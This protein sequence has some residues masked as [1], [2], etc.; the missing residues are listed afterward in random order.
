MQQPR[1]AP[2]SNSTPDMA[3]SVCGRILDY[4]TELD[5]SGGHWTHT[6][7]DA[8]VEDHRAVPVEVGSGNVVALYRCDFCNQD[9]ATWTVPATDF[10]VAP[11]SN[12]VGD[13]CACWTCAQFIARDDWIALLEH[14]IG[15]AKVNGVIAKGDVTEAEFKMFLGMTYPRLQQ[16]ITGPPHPGIQTSS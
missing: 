11:L 9:N 2:I 7:Q 3:C 4:R 16:H 13:W 10:Q 14:A 8:K 1:S 5:G 15:W 12:S 6:T